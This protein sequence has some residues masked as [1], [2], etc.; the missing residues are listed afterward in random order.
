VAASIALLPTS[1]R[2]PGGKPLAQSIAARWAVRTSREPNH[3]MARRSDP[4]S[5][6]TEASS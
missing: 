3:P 6:S 2:R 5:Q 1:P 4:G